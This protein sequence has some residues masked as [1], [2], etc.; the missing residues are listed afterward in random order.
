MANLTKA[1]IVSQLLKTEKWKDYKQSTLMAKTKDVLLKLLEESKGSIIVP[2]PK[3]NENTKTAPAPAVAEP[4]KR[5][6]KKLAVTDSSEQ[7]NSLSNTDYIPLSKRNLV[8]TT[9]TIKTGSLTIK[10]T[11]WK[12]PNFVVPE[13]PEAPKRGRKAT[14][15]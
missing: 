14:K 5:S 3:N 1:E 6:G 15:K 8:S 10:Y 13:V 7:M 4:K 11:T 9:K 2:A 12:D